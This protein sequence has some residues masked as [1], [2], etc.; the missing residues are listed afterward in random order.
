MTILNT[1]SDYAVHSIGHLAKDVS[2]V[3]GSITD[4]EIV[5]K[6]VRGQE[7]VVHMAARTNVDES[8]E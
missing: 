1:L 6:T 4:P 8:R 5:G 2:I 7:L 3:W